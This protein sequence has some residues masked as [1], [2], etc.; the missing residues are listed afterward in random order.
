MTKICRTCKKSLPVEVFRVKTKGN[1]TDGR[2]PHCP[3]C[4][5]QL[6]REL[7]QRK[8]KENPE[9]LFRS[10][11]DRNL[12]KKFGIGIDEFESLLASQNNLCKIC[13]TDTPRGR[14]SFVVDHNHTTGKIRGLL[15]TECNV[16]LGM[17]K[18]SIEILEKAI[19]Y[20]KEDLNE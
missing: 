2:G 5:R 18:D 16:G 6:A 20:L 19:T 12:K 15:C 8:K 10:N 9:A 4:E 11:K 13:K 1:T 14:G 17:M 3:P 7:Y